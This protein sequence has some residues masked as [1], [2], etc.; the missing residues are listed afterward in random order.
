MH[1]N[2]FKLNLN[3]CFRTVDLIDV[4]MD[5]NVY[6]NLY[7]ALLFCPMICYSVSL[8]AKVRIRM[9]MKA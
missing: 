4:A 3:C 7:S 9:R 5:V 8:L 2:I 6:T 1:G